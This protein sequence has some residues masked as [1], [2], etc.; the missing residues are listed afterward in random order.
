MRNS[1]LL[2]LSL[3]CL[4]LLTAT[5]CSTMAP[6]QVASAPLKQYDAC[7]YVPNSPKCHGQGM[8]TRAIETRKAYAAD[9]LEREARQREAIARR[10]DRDL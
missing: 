6:E 8:S 10:V 2:V 1:F 5:G 9:V 4:Y 3:G 7:R